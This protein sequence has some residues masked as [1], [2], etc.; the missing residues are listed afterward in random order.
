MSRNGKSELYL[1]RIDRQGDYD[2]KEEQIRWFLEEG[3]HPEA[4]AKAINFRRLWG[5]E[6][7]RKAFLKEM[8]SA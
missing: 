3:W 2:L 7:H 4:K 1:V 5:R 6:K 8:E